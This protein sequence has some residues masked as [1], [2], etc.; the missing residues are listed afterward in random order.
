MVHL[1]HLAAMC[2]AATALWAGVA[3][4]SVPAT[5]GAPSSTPPVA[6]AT[7]DDFYGRHPATVDCVI[8]AANKQGVP[9]NVLLALASIEAGKNGQV[10]QQNKNGSVDLSHFQ[11]N[12]GN[13]DR[14]G[15]FAKYPEITKEA[16]LWRGCYNAELAAWL[17]RKRLDEPTGQDF[18]TRAA[19]YHSKTPQFNAVYRR[20]LIPLAVQWGK[21]LQQRVPSALVS[22]QPQTRNT[23]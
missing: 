19:N 9:A 23:P 5:P 14:G 15:E 1:S 13:W 16:V 6:Q 18:W 10:S 17:L 11:I 4:A 21:W 22:Y 3:E 2:F 8:E 20:K 7:D 12:T